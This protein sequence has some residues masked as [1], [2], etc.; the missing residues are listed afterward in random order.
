MTNK[1]FNRE[2]TRLQQ[3]KKTELLIIIAAVVLVYII[4]SQYDIMERIIAFSMRYENWEADEI[5][6]VSIFLGFAFLIFAIRRWHELALIQT[7]LSRRNEELE[8]ALTEITQLRGILPICS[9]CKQIRDDEGYW[10]QVDLYITKHSDAKFTHS[11]CPDC[12]RE[13]YPE[14]FEKQVQEQE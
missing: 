2:L 3:K 13:L 1:E 6:T 4:A 5:L 11:I 8:A 12:A 9:K 7:M 14:L 10:H